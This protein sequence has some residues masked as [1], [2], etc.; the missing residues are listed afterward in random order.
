MGEIKKG[1][2]DTERSR[3]PA[4][5]VGWLVGIGAGRE[6]GSGGGREP[7][8]STAPNSLPGSRA[9]CTAQHHHQSPGQ[10]LSACV[11]PPLI[12]LQWRNP[13]F[14]L[15]QEN[16]EEAELSAQSSVKTPA[17]WRNTC[18]ARTPEMD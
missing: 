18:F 11:Q 14:V 3:C 5:R 9:A 17:S 13:C 12:L 10:I 6:A 1:G 15:R 4:R 2:K 7:A 16:E 8:T